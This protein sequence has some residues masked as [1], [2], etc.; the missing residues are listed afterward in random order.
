M[1]K[2]KEI[3]NDLSSLCVLPG[4]VHALAYISCRDNMVMYSGE[5]T[6]KDMSKSYSK[7]RLIRTEIS[8]LIGL[9]IK[10]SIDYSL[11]DPKTMQL[12]IDKTEA[13]LEEM[14]EAMNSGFFVGLDPSKLI[15]D[16]FNPFANGKV[17]REPIFYSGES[18]YSFQY[19]EFSS[20]KYQA[21]NAWLKSNYGFSI[22]EARDIVHAVSKLQNE[23]VGSMHSVL[24]KMHPNEWSMLSAFTFTLQ[25]VIDKTKINSNVI[26]SVLKSFSITAGSVNMGF[27]A[28]HDFNIVNAFPLIAKD[29]NT[30]ILF[31]SY[32]LVEALYEAPFYWMGADKKYC[33]TAMRNRG[34]FTEVF[35]KQ[36]L[37]SV[38]GKNNVFANVDILE[39]KGKKAGEIDVL[40]LFGNR[41]IVLQAKS[42]RLTQEAKRGNDGQI[43]DDFKKSVQDSYDQGLSCAKLLGNKQYQFVVEGSQA[44]EIPII[45]KEIYVFCVVADHY[46]A[47]SFQT[48]QFLKYEATDVIKPPF[49]LDV[50]TLDAVAEMLQSPLFFLSYVNRRTSY[51]DKLM[52]TNELTILSYHLKVNLWMNDEYGL[53]VLDDDISVDLDLAMTVRRDGIQGKST[54]EGILTRFT[55]STVGKMVQSISAKPD[56]AVIDLGFM[57]L[58]LSE[59]SVNNLSKGINKIAQMA[60]SDGKSHDLTITFGKNETGLTIHCNSNPIY[61]AGP[62]LEGHCK[63]RKYSEKV[64]SWFGV[65]ISPNDES[66][67]FGLNLNYKWETSASMDAATS[68]MKRGEDFLKVIETMQRKP[69]TGR[70][71]LCP[72]GSGLKYKKCCLSR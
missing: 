53:V 18:A 30:F 21:D 37:E 63:K 8:T 19:R 46:P 22:N 44:I 49:V 25:E 35:S 55:S 70:N 20:L 4:Y 48:R 56:P 52:A 7:K 38:F 65:C 54:P 10:S 66:L 60:R 28:I 47:L 34:V 72:C 15:K 6:S 12:Y 71:E 3:F 69:K 62:S 61:I 17:L 64:N 42:K 11:P 51:S 26:N 13:L 59:D 5:M 27:S 1:R 43:K 33:S 23:K 57:L 24:R 29:G 50:F 58:T 40:V 9:L 36:R 31:H 41:A 2:E 14:H 39:S 45:L 68:E 32:S 16:E 67:R